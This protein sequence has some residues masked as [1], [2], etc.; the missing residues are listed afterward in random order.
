MKKREPRNQGPV[1]IC[2]KIS[3]AAGLVREQA[4]LSDEERLEKGSV[5]YDS[6][7]WPSKKSDH[8]HGSQ[9][10]EGSALRSCINLWQY[11]RW[12]TSTSLGSSL[13]VH[14]SLYLLASQEQQEKS[15]FVTAF[16]ICRFVCTVRR[17]IAVSLAREEMTSAFSMADLVIAPALC[18]DPQR[19][20]LQISKILSSVLSRSL[21]HYK[22]RQRQTLRLHPSH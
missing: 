10:S 14:C 3:K 15:I 20:H 2:H 7:S 6:I 13:E 22:G 11:P 17:S 4:K 18:G 16:S 5:R 12:L 19:H 21:P 1:L 9:I 8:H